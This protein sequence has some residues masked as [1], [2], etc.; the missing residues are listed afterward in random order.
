M[1]LTLEKDNS[2]LLEYSSNFI[3]E[4]TI[5]LENSISYLSFY[6]LTL[7]NSNNQT[8]TDE[9]TDLSNLLKTYAYLYNIKINIKNLIN[10]DHTNNN[11]LT[12]DP[13]DS[14]I[15]SYNPISTIDI[16]Q[17]NLECSSLHINN[18]QLTEFW[19]T[20]TSLWNLFIKFNAQSK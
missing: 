10:T 11:L 5:L 1:F 16:E 15:T 14:T 9:L 3:T 18:N 6:I 4:L 2:I 7:K 13:H 8:I 17:L 12:F 20:F 19:T